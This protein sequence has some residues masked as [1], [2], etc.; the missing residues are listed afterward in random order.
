MRIHIYLNEEFPR[1]VSNKW[2]LNKSVRAAEAEVNKVKYQYPNSGQL[3]ALGAAA[4]RAAARRDLP[5]K[6][7]TDGI[8]R[9]GHL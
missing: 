9:K 8:A 6:H 5:I 7:A 1:F 3:E 4:A 2:R